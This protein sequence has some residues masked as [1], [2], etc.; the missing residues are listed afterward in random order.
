[1]AALNSRML[2]MYTSFISNFKLLALDVN[3]N[4]LLSQILILAMNPVTNSRTL[5]VHTR[6]MHSEQKLI[7][8]A[9]LLISRCYYDI[10]CRQTSKH[11]NLGQ[12]VEL[13][14]GTWL[15]PLYFYVDN[16]FINQHSVLRWI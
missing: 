1:M 14:D 6:W 13:R 2:E 16:S 11:G 7:T 4:R 5:F 10:H 8:G 3:Q 12:D 9:I 15:N